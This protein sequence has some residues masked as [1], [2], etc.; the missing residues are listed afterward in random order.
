[1]GLGTFSA[2]GDVLPQQPVAFHI[3]QDEEGEG[4]WSGQ[5]IHIS[6]CCW[7]HSASKPF[8]DGS[9]KRIGFVDQVQAGDLPPPQAKPAS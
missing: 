2:K 1:M 9:H 4:F 3:P 5:M 6:R 7:M 8:C